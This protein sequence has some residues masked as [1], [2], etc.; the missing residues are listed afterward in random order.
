MK[1]TLNLNSSRGAI[2]TRIMYVCVF[3]PFLYATKASRLGG[4]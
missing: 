3:V 1:H 4:K 2:K